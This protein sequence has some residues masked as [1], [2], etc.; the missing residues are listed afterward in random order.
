MIFMIKDSHLKRVQE[1]AE[2]LIHAF[3][4]NLF[5]LTHT[6]SDKVLTKAKRHTVVM[7][8]HSIQRL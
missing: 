1:V 4:Y 7:S 6:Y 5:F 8:V 3:Y 2:I